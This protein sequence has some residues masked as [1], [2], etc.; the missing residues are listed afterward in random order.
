M[1]GY[2]LESIL[3]TAIYSWE[4][5][6]QYD[7]KMPFAFLVI[8]SFKTRNDNRDKN[9]VW[10]VTEVR[11][12]LNCGWGE[13]GRGCGNF[14]RCLGCTVSVMAAIKQTCFR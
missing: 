14:G 11:L 9:H 13:L 3:Q 5:S 1:E 10:E 8:D 12:C 2:P 7:H 6:N 4:I